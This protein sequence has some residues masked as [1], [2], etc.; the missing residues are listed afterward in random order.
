MQNQGVNDKKPSTAILG[1]RSDRNDDTC[2]S[3]FQTRL[4]VWELPSPLLAT[5]DDNVSLF[6]KEARNVS[7]F[8]DRASPTLIVS[9]GSVQLWLL[10][11]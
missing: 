5:T 8:P 7:W 2:E 11:P 3:L 9:L 1:S 4:L 10:V 6:N